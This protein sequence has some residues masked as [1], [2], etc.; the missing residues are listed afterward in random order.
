MLGYV[1]T[2]DSA[3]LHDWCRR[4]QWFVKKNEWPKF[5]GLDSPRYRVW[6]AM[7]AWSLGLCL[8]KKYQT[9]PKSI[10]ELVIVALW[11]IW[12]K[13]LQDPVDTHILTR[14]FIKQLTECIKSHGAF[15]A[16]DTRQHICYR[17]A[18]P[19]RLSVRHMGGLVNKK[20]SCRKDS[21]PYC[22]T[23]PFG[24][25][26]TSSVT[27]T[28]HSPYAI[29]CWWSFGTK[30]LSLTVSEIFNVECNAMVDITLIRPLNKGQG[31]SFWY[32]SICHIRLP[33]G[34]Q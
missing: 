4:W 22:L 28:F 13:L 3:T 21:R 33:I 14:S 15:L 17:I 34:C 12:N 24:G 8:C 10:S 20:P 23:A 11:S 19:V 7:H 27:W 26:V 32:Q 29:S 30:P 6:G 1:N 25:H 18:P 16:H 5:T 9:R 2:A 31:H